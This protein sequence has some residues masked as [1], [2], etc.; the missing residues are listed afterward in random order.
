MKTFPNCNFFNCQ[1]FYAM[2]GNEHAL[3]FF[4][5][6]IHQAPSENSFNLTGKKSLP[7]EIILCLNAKSFFF[8]YISTDKINKATA[9]L[10][11]LLLFSY[12]VQLTVCHNL[13]PY[14]A[15]FRY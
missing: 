7:M 13:Y 10:T 14:T 3:Y 12:L 15:K 4:C 8:K 2:K 6:Q 1:L 5:F 9:F 11:G